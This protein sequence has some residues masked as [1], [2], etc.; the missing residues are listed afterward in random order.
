MLTRKQLDLLDF[1]KKRMVRDGVPP[2]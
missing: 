1:I 2:S